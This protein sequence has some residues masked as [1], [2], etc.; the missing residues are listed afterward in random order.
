VKALFQFLDCAVA[1][2]E[3]QLCLHLCVGYI[4]FISFSIKRYLSLISSPV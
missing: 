2:C 3:L 4:S 1:L